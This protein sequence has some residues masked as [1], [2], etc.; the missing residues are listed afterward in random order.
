MVAGAAVARASRREQGP[1]GNSGRRRM[2]YT[3][4]LN[5]YLTGVEL[6]DSQ[7]LTLAQSMNRL[8]ELLES[9]DSGDQLDTVIRDLVEYFQQHF[10]DEEKL[11]AAHPQLDLHRR[12]HKKFIT[13]TREYA[14]E[15]L[16]NRKRE[17]AGEMLSFLY[18]W[19]LSH[20]LKMDKVHF[21]ELAAS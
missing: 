4:W 13:K 3:E 2:D 17:V 7:H 19:F 1:G 9:S 8:E 11:L 15:V 20:T 21:A 5:K 14:Q 18:V 12:E 10:S 6:V 16:V